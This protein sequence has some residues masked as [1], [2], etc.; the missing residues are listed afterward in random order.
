MHLFEF[1]DLKWNCFC[2][3][4]IF[5]KKIHQLLDNLQNKDDYTW[6]IDQVKSGHGVVLNLLGSKSR[7]L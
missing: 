5:L 2:F 4:N 1:E 3:T 6:N 7:Y